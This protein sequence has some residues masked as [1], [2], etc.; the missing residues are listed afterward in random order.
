M[1]SWDYLKEQRTTKAPRGEE[2]RPTHQAPQAQG[3]HIFVFKYKSPS[4]LA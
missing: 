3:T 1:D 4:H 2:N